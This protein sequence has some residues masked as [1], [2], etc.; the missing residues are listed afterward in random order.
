MIYFQ[1]NDQVQATKPRGQ[2]LVV[3]QR[4][5]LFSQPIRMHEESNDNEN[6]NVY[7]QTTKC[8]I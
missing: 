1:V 5:K 3:T 6:K 2:R 7:A 8:K 4:P